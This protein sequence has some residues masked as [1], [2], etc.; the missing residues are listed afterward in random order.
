M[1]DFPIRIGTRMSARASAEKYI[2]ILEPG[3]EWDK[4]IERLS[5]NVTSIKTLAFGQ[6]VIAV[7][8]GSD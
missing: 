4:S 3:M 6:N 1:I 8:L 2:F 5:S 7:E